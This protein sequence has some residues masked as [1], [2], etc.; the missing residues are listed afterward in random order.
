M[1]PTVPRLPIE[2]RHLDDV[3]F[4][5]SEGPAF[6]LVTVRLV[7]ATGSAG[8]VAVPGVS[9][10]AWEMCERGAGRYGRAEFHEEL[11]LTGAEW[12]MHV[13]RRSTVVDIRVLR[14]GLGRALELVSQALTS[15]VDDPEELAS[16][17]VEV[18]EREQTVLEDPGALVGQGLPAAMWPGSSWALTSAGTRDTRSRIDRATVRSRRT[19]MLAAPLIVGIG[20]E[21]P[22]E[23][24]PQVRAFV[25]GLRNGPSMPEDFARPE[26]AWGTAHAYEF[27]ADQGA[28]TVLASAP[29]PSDPLWPAVALHCAH[30]G[31]G[32]SSPLME[33]IRSREGLSYEL[34]WHVVPEL[35]AGTHV[36]RVYPESRHVARALSLV[37][38]CWAES[39]RAP[40]SPEALA[41]S[42]ASLIGNRLVA[43]ETVERRMIAAVSTR[44]IGLPIARLWE[45][46]ARVSELESADLERAA[47]SL[48]WATGELVAVSALRG[49]ARSSQWDESPLDPE[50][51][52]PEALL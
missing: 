15:P 6:G 12:S 41:R 26:P 1:I 17:L 13:A 27:D 19:R 46:P 43:L 14:E 29:L 37:H 51:R 33:A 2:S 52:N 47:S 20:A 30:F 25:S 34:A 40:A 8:D 45:L 32:F 44:V 48:G 36:F 31:Q 35:D 16:L 18:D 38:E 9:A 23:V 39:A 28:L 50:A 22:E 5:L 11:E 4:V 42:K 7:F 21:S 49:G 24:L 3:E 10:I